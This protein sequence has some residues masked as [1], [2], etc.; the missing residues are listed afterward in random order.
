VNIAD[1][2][3]DTRYV[4]AI[5]AK[6]GY[7]ST[8][9]ACAPIVS[10]GMVIGIIQATNKLPRSRSPR[11]VS[12]VS[13]SANEALLLGF[14]AANVGLS[15]KK[16]NLAQNLS[17]HAMNNGIDIHRAMDLNLSKKLMRLENDKSLQS[18]MDFAYNRLDAERVSIF[19]YNSAQKNLVCTV[20][21]DI[22]GFSIPHDKGFA[23]LAFTA[24][25]IINVP[26]TEA[27]DRHNK[28]VDNFV[29]FKTR[30][31]LCAPIISPDGTALGVIQ[32]VN[33]R[34]NDASFTYVDEEQIHEVCNMMVS[35]LREKATDQVE[36]KTNETAPSSSGP[37]MSALSVAFAR[38]IGNM[39][40]STT[41]EELVQTL[42]HAILANT[43]FDFVRAYVTDGDRLLR[44]SNKRGANY[45]DASE[46]F[47]L[48]DLNIQ[49]K[50]ALQFSALVE[51][52][53][54]SS[55]DMNLLPDVKLQQAFV[56]PASTKAYPFEPGTCVA[57]IG[58]TSSSTAV[59]EQTRELLDLAMEYF[60]LAVNAIAERIVME[61]N[62]KQLRNQVKILSASLNAVPDY[63]MVFNQEGVLL[64]KNKCLDDLL[65]HISNAD[66]EDSENNKEE[67]LVPKEKMITEGM[68]WKEFINDGHSPDLI[69]DLEN[70]FNQQESKNMESIRLTT[71]TYPDGINIDY[72]ITAVVNPDLQN[73]RSRS[74][75]SPVEVS[76]SK[77]HEN[78]Q[79]DSPSNPANNNHTNNFFVVIVIHVNNQKLIDLS[80]VPTNRKTKNIL[81]LGSVTN[82]V[83]AASAIIGAIRTNFA[84]DQD[85]E[86]NLKEIMT[87]LAFTSR[88]M[89]LAHVNYSA[90]TQAIHSANYLLVNPDIPLP[91]NMFEWEFNSMEIKDSL[92][93]CNIMG[94][95]FDS[96][97][98]LDELNVDSSSLARYIAEVGRHYHDRPFH[99]LQHA[100]CVTH[101]TY[102]LIKGFDAPKS[103]KQHLVFSILLGAVV[104][105]IDHPGNTNLFEINSQSDLAIRYNDQSVLENHHCST[106]FRLMRKTNM[107][108]LA[109]LPK[110]TAVEVRKYV[111]S[112]VMATDMAVHFELI[113]E[114]KRRGVEGWNFEEIKDQNFLGKMLLHAADLSNPVR[115]YHMTKEWARRISLEFNDQVKRELAL[116]MPVLGFMMTPDEK[117]FCKNEMG[118]AS[119]VVA[120]MWRAIASCFPNVQFLVDQLD[121]NVATWK[122]RLAD[123]QAEEETAAAAAEAKEKETAAAATEAK[124]KEATDSKEE[125]K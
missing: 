89:S 22:K 65:G 43:D 55:D 16:S 24:K 83:D 57:V 111:I 77:Y 56:M 27:D 80:A 30:S 68:F 113:D 124:E 82:G 70:A 10:E 36:K 54:S 38:S 118:F 90:I 29:G 63:V 5:D 20:S 74:P 116:G 48:I 34:G 73:S 87:S 75:N 51:Y 79:T 67:P 18:L 96:L 6:L 102:M 97:F 41:L 66:L 69:R 88:R 7:R 44:V 28:D 49:L 98:N 117:A 13:F 81:D 109:R 105:D 101:F 25:R 40:L 100:T 120:P 108:V 72:Q 46:Q 52:K 71:T 94:K 125:N 91:S 99:N 95:Y 39:V 31:L 37:Q 64:G 23:G 114:T 104:H 122:N 110:G 103:L 121:S 112:C 92:V 21:Q 9:I 26:N 107:Q 11:D 76:E 59:S 60:S 14:I 19:T 33:K 53:Y 1:L 85:V 42:E 3:Q 32:A 115:P 4:P 2:A 47:K 78:N 12:A 58:S 45:N 62:L 106:A 15:L 84:L 35:I 123:I 93:L 8:C 61:E 17:N 119:F 50:Q 86:E